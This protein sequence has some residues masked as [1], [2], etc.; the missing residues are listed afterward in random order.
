MEFSEIPGKQPFVL[1]FRTGIFKKGSMNKSMQR[2]DLQRGP[3]HL[4]VTNLNNIYCSLSL[5]FIKKKGV[6]NPTPKN[7]TTIT[8]THSICHGQPHTD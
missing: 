7:S 4:G 8:D 3:I 2:V 6:A 5:L 1:K